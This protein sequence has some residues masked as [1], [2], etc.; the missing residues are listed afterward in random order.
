MRY[1]EVEYSINR[2]KHSISLQKLKTAKFKETIKIGSLLE[3]D[4][5]LQ[6][7]NLYDINSLVIDV[8][9]KG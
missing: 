8:W 2:V 9:G 7:H 6:Q 3:L 4:F 1:Q 5:Q